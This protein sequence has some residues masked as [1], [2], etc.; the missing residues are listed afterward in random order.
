[1][2]GLDLVRR[3]SLPDGRISVSGRS[4]T[5]NFGTHR[6]RVADP[7]LHRHD[8]QPGEPRDDPV[9]P[10]IRRPG[11]Q[12]DRGLGGDERVA[13]LGNGQRERDRR[14]Q[15]AEFTTEDASQSGDGLRSSTAPGRSGVVDRAEAPVKVVVDDADVLHECI[16]TRGPHEAVPLRLQLLRERLRLRSRPG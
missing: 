6:P 15:L 16:Y 8:V 14:A 7:L 12:V 4:R 10:Q 13:S 5:R 2:L 3:R 9:E 1:M 11:Q